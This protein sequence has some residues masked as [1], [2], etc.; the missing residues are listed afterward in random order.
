MKSLVKK[1]RG[2]QITPVTGKQP[3]SQEEV[4]WMETAQA[5]DS[6]IGMS[7]TDVKID[8]NSPEI[9]KPLV[10][11]APKKEI[12]ALLMKT[13]QDIDKDRLMGKRLAMNIVRKQRDLINPEP[14]PTLSFPV[15]TT[16]KKTPLIRRAVQ[17]L[18]PFT[19]TRPEQPQ[20]HIPGV[21]ISESRPFNPQELSDIRRD[22]AQNGQKDAQFMV[23][24]WE[25]GADTIML[26][27]QEMRRVK[28]I[29]E[30][31]SIYEALEHCLDT[32][33]GDTY[34]LMDW[35]TAAWRLAFPTLDLTQF[36]TAGKWNTYAE[37]I[38]ICRKLGILWFIYNQAATPQASPMLP[39]FKKI[40]I[41]GAPPHLRMSLTG[42]IQGCN[43]VADTIQ[44]FKSFRELEAEWVVSFNATA[45]PIKK[46]R[47]RPFQNIKKQIRPF[48]RTSG[49]NIRPPLNGGPYQRTF[50]KMVNS[51]RKNTFL[52]KRGPTAPRFRNAPLNNRRWRGNA[53]PVRAKM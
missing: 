39:A 35:I 40:I 6:R 51:W 7:A 47:P 50:G 16:T 18:N 36:E 12:P 4:K 17:S 2:I 38:A 27:E 26:H 41:K 32:S 45:K 20:G 49:M 5:V 30:N 23:R 33:K 52:G 25:K 8:L 3:V 37:A 1:I 13:V 11:K 34:P 15:I 42:S 43:T 28:G 31:P 53:R 22:Y 24:L 48:E 14:S 19:P 21:E 29:I 44:F 10:E 46:P 9:V